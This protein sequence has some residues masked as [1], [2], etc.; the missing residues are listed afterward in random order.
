MK[1]TIP[2]P[3]DEIRIE[4]NQMLETGLDGI[5]VVGFFDLDSTAELVRVRRLSIIGNEIRQCASRPP[6]PTPSALVDQMGYGAVTLADVEDLVIR[7]NLI[8]S[9][10][11][12][13]QG[14]VCGVFVLSGT[15]VE[16]SGNRLL[17]NGSPPPMTPGVAIDPE[18]V[19]P[20]RGGIHIVHTV[21]PARVPRLA[22][23]GGSGPS[24]MTYVPASVPTGL[25][26]LRVH[27]NIVNSPA[28]PALHA[29]GL[30]SMSVAGN[31]FSCTGL[32][33]RSPGLFSPSTVFIMN[34]GTSMDLTQETD[35]FSRILA[36]EKLSVPVVSFAN[37]H[38]RMAGGDVLFT[39]NQCSLRLT[40]G[41]SDPLFASIVLASL[42]DI[43]FEN[44]HSTCHLPRT[45][46]LVV[47][48]TIVY[49][50]T[51]RVVGNRIK[52]PLSQ[53]AYS[54]WTVGLMN[55]TT[56]NQTTH[57]LH[58]AG[59]ETTDVP[60]QVSIATVSSG[61]KYCAPNLLATLRNRQSFVNLLNAL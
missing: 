31:Q 18:V 11:A 51:V 40:E 25:P 46:D 4:R 52:E 43:A 49:A 6:A 27:D 34:L 50:P 39:N 13:H 60:N 57:C 2:L 16:I 22:K 8:E 41:A 48:N 1:R 7:D 20:R 21:A 9:N 59:A 24:G 30:G 33:P 23:A 55:V 42:D 38:L 28:G 58:V 36:R 45:Q 54:L 15:G 29:T 5:G 53:A 17:G 32:A 35:R 12:N 61:Q 19:T 44:N 10:G 47:A 3:L 26:A 37:L 56:H 14:A